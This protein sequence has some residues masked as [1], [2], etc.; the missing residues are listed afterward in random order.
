MMRHP[1]S[2]ASPLRVRHAVVPVPGSGG[3]LARV[4][5]RRQVRPGQ[6]VMETFT[7][8][9]LK[10]M[11]S[12]CVPLKSLFAFVCHRPKL[13]Y[14]LH[15]SVPTPSTTPL[16][17]L[18]CRPDHL[19]SP[20]CPCFSTWTCRTRHRRAQCH[21]R[22]GR[23][24]TAAPAPRTPPILSHPR[25]SVIFSHPVSPI[26]SLLFPRDC[27]T[28][29]P[30]LSLLAGRWREQGQA[31]R[32]AWRPVGVRRMVRTQGQAGPSCGAEPSGLLAAVRGQNCLHRRG[33]TRRR[34]RRRAH[35]WPRHK[36]GPVA[37]GI[38]ADCLHRRR[39]A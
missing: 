36:T 35:G 38:A 8:M 33:G 3:C 5:R 16:S 11:V 30:C 32:T 31:R 20:K 9:V 39:G 1:A 15:H 2:R 19:L 7:C 26:L 34:A 14:P 29:T 27:Q 18:T 10:K 17:H 24:L 22:I 12:T 21:D 23:P 37:E 28:F 13:F 4:Y 25:S 6:L